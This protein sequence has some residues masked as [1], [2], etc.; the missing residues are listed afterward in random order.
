MDDSGLAVTSAVDWS[1]YSSNDRDKTRHL[2]IALCKLSQHWERLLY[3]TVGAINFQKS[4]W[5]LLSW[6]W[7]KGIPTLA[8]IQD[9]PSDLHLTTGCHRLLDKVP[10]INPRDAFHTLVVYISPSGSQKKQIS[11]LRGYSETYSTT[12]HSSTLTPGEA[13]WSYSLYLHPKLTGCTSLTQ[14]QC[15]YIQA[16]ALAALLPK[17]HLNHHT[18]HAV[19]FS[20]S[21]LGGLSLPDLYT[22]QGHY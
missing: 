8:K 11:V 7:K 19:L 5:H 10:R 21:R 16:S 9:I 6:T 18:P 1:N 14:Q 13:Y 17:M 4:F 22:D 3:S 20:E 2:V 15:K 12:I